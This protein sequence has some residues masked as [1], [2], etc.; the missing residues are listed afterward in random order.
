MSADRKD[1]H[2]GLAGADRS[3]VP[4][5]TRFTG[6]H[7]HRPLYV[8]ATPGAARAVAKECKE[9]PD[10]ADFISG[11]MI[12]PAAYI[13]TTPTAL[14]GRA[15]DLARLAAVLAAPE[16]GLVTVTGPAGVGK[17]RLVMEYFRQ[18]QRGRSA[19]FRASSG[20]LGVRSHAGAARGA[21]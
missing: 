13:G 10:F 5:A 12:S 11:R 20:R 16:A 15:H 8:N 2:A 4:P 18:R 14:I 3:D 17:S 19:R 9:T 21:V 6:I 1:D 7:W